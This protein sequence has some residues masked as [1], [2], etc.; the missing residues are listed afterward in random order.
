MSIKNQMLRIRLIW[1]LNAK[2]KSF[3]I[4]YRYNLWKVYYACKKE[5][6]IQYKIFNEKCR[7]IVYVG[8]DER[9]DK[10]GFMQALGKKFEVVIPFTKSNGEWG[11]Y[12][13]KDTCKKENIKRLRNIIEKS[14]CK[15]DCII[16]QSWGFA[17][18]AEELLKLKNEHNF[19][20]INIDMDSRLIYRKIVYRG[21]QNP[22]IYGLAKCTDLFLVTTKEIVD[23][24]RKE[25]IPALYF[26][27]ASSDS[28]YHPIQC[29]RKYD[30]GFIG[31]NYGIRADLIKYLNSNGIAV[32]TRGGGWPQGEIRFEDNNR[33]FNE[34]RIV[35]GIGNI[36]Y[37]R[38]FYNPKLR[39]YDAPM[40]GSVYITNWTPELQNDFLENREIVLYRKRKELVKK[41]RW[42]LSNQKVMEEI[43]KASHEAAK[44]RHSYEKR[45]D[46]VFRYICR[47]W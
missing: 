20:I 3:G 37:C 1:M 13:E 34:C 46:E 14:K 41:I 11:Q 31:G 21:K 23:W 44:M 8:A 15:I 35:L 19:K 38:N 27:L 24:Y 7:N 26:P 36:S 43:R 40:S 6:A 25:G 45:I 2:I 32:E 16:M 4:L 33:F 28:F 17:F 9:Q 39:D 12:I 30:V 42:L 18:D 22:G 47:E 10:S 5:K 29:E